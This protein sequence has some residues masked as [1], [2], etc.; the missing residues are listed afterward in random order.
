MQTPERQNWYSLQH[1]AQY[2][3]LDSAKL[4]STGEC[5]HC[6]SKYCGFV[7]LE[8]CGPSTWVAQWLS[9]N[10]WF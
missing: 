1:P 8:R 4:T 6:N 7:L 10:S 5:A 3:S 9:D 2:S